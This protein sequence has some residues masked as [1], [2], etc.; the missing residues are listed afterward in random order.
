[1]RRRFGLGAGAIL[2][3]V[4]ACGLIVGGFYLVNRYLG[5]VSA[6][7]DPPLYPGAQ[8]VQRQD[9]GDM[10]QNVAYN[11]YIMRVVTFT[12]SVGPAE[13]KGYYADKL[14]R[15]GFA[16]ADW[17]RPPP[18]PDTLRFSWT[19]GG[20]SPSVY[21]LDVTAWPLDSGG[22]RIEIGASMFPGY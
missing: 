11:T 15:R 13:V 17:G 16:P 7:Y 1:M 6:W 4:L 2:L 9:F 10:G 8:Q 14:P 18:A 19:G 21:F 5:P 12:V 3:G 22:T 20:R